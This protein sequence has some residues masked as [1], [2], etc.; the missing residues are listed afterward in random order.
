MESMHHFNDRAT[1]T[2]HDWQIE[3]SWAVYKSSVACRIHLFPFVDAVDHAVERRAC[4]V[5]V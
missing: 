4:G 2:L 5:F 1:V 3:S